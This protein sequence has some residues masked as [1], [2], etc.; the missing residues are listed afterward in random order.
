MVLAAELDPEG[1]HDAGD[2]S[3]AVDGVTAGQREQRD[4]RIGLLLGRRTHL[5]PPG[6]VDPVEYR[7]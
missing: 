2:V 6:L 7:N 1:H 5:T 3:S 4:D